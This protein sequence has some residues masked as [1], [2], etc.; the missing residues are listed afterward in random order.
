MKQIFINPCAL[1]AI[2]FLTQSCADKSKTPAVENFSA[3]NYKFKPAPKPAPKKNTPKPEATA[4]LP[5]PDDD[6][7]RLPEDM[8]AL[9]NAA[10]L[11]STA[12]RKED[13][14]TLVTRPP[15]A[16]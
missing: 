6:G 7:L 11:K 8:L 10:A 15:T 16:E 4:E 13:D 2:T 9:P 3:E 12:P 5:K 14:A 1:L